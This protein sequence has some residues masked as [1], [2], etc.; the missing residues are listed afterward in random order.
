MTSKKRLCSVLVKFPNFRSK[1]QSGAI[2]FFRFPRDFCTKKM[3]SLSTAQVGKFP[4]GSTY[5]CQLI[6]VTPSGVGVRRY[7]MVAIFI[8]SKL[9]LSRFP[10]FTD[11]IRI[12]IDLSG[13]KDV[14]VV[15]N[16]S[17]DLK[18]K[19]NFVIW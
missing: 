8:S 7:S 14:L 10:F 2:I 18:G 1:P 13:F 12:L 16:T 6:R 17:L 11:S 19:G 15:R 5:C 9:D 4:P 3:F